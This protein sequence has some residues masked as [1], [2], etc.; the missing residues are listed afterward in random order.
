M[1]F[2]IISWIFYGCED[3]LYFILS[4]SLYSTIMNSL[5]PFEIFTSLRYDPVLSSITGNRV[6]RHDCNESQFYMLQYHYDRLVE[7]MQQFKLF[8]V[9]PQMQSLENF[10]SY[11][12]EEAKEQKERNSENETPFKVCSELDCFGCNEIAYKHELMNAR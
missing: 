11:L 9:G 8:N 10:A 6:S 1:V 3:Y 2:W 12:V 4:R 5:K 7:A